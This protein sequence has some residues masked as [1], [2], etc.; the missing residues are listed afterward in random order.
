MPFI[1]EPEH[2]C[3]LPGGQYPDKYPNAKW[4]CDECGRVWKTVHESPAYDFIRDRPM[5]A[6][7]LWKMTGDVM[8]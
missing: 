7:W 2:G 1:Q 4:Y 5:R 6:I 8:A 3:N